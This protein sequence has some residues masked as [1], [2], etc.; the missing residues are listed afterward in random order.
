MNKEAQFHEI[1]QQA[2]QLIRTHQHRE[3]TATTNYKTAGIYMIYVNH[4]VD[5]QFV[6]IYIGQAKDIQKRYKDHYTE[7]LALNRLSYEEYKHY[8]FSK[9]P[10][11]YEGRF[12]T[13]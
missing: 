2:Q 8:F 10:S 13:S 1:K 5:D 4:F 9:S 6:P 12:K 3:V 11:L 7:I